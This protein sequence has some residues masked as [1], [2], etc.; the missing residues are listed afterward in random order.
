[1]NGQA[2]VS[3]P[4]PGL[5]E[6]MR[7]R[8]DRCR[9]RPIR[10]DLRREDQ[11][12]GAPRSLVNTSELLRV[13]ALGGVPPYRDPA[14]QKALRHCIDAIRIARQGGRILGRVSLPAGHDSVG[15]TTSARSPDRFD[16]SIRRIAD[17]R[18]VRP[19]KRARPTASRSATPLNRSGIH[20]GAPAS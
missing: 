15:P 20:T 12:P 11:Y 16:E 4:P 14:V 6:R 5:S 7:V 2:T 9:A 3:R 10:S 13:F 18:P 19:W 17:V 8:F 1:V